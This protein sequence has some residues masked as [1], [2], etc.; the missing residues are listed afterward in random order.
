MIG[1]TI[2]HYQVLD[3]LGEGGMGVVYKA[4]DTHRDRFV[5]IKVLPPEKVAD[6]ERKRRFVQEAKAASALNHPNIV[7]IH[8]ITSDAG[9]DF[10]VMEHVAG[11]TL[12]QLI[13]RKGLKLSEALKCAVQMAD[14]LA[15]A[16]AA[17]I[18]HR[19]L[20]PGNVMVTGDGLV[21]VLDFG[22]AKLTEPLTGE[23][24]PTQTAEGTI[25]GTV[26]Y[27]S[28]EQ[29][30]GKPVDTRSDIFSFGSVLYEMLTGQRAFKGDSRV[31]TLAAVLRQ[32][33]ALMGEEV[34]AELRRVVARCLRKDPA[35]RFQ[36]MDDVKIA[37]E[38]LKE[39]SDSGSL[40]ST[41]PQ[42]KSRRRLIWLLAGVTLVAVAALATWLARRGA[43]APPADARAVPLTSFAGYEEHPSFSPDG[44]QIAFSWN[45][46]KQ[47][48]QDIYVQLIGTG[49]VV[50]ITTDPA[51]DRVPA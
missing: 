19:D 5:A 44:T 39:E 25:V 46:E 23:E 26:A 18:I 38:E 7:T 22:L 20:K 13:G 49:S 45:G 24:A 41:A 14:A 48:N 1:R 4:R 28:P 35:R 9:C 30:E 27:M 50:R 34:P 17:G 3:K 15:K 21:K 31:S 37:L 2:A 6:P 42:R 12:D 29:A 51:P 33:P 47:D 11:K 8:D 32:E 10:I 16:H 36:H 40:V 43:E